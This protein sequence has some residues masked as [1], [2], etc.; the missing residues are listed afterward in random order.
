MLEQHLPR[1][2]L[3]L[4]TL[5]DLFFGEVVMQFTKPPM[6]FDEQVAQLESRGM[7]IGD[8]DRAKRYLSHLNYYREA[9]AERSFY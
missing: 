2:S 7:V 1:I 5:G 4:R 9:E 8:K 3:D 6:T